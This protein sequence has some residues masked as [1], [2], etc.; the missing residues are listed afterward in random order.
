MNGK[1]TTSV[2]DLLGKSKQMICPAR[3]RLNSAIAKAANAPKW[4]GPAW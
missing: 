3:A 4:Y 1:S 2:Y